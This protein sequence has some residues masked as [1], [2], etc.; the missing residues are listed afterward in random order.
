MFYNKYVYLSTKITVLILGSLT[1]I[2]KKIYEEYFK[3]DYL[4]S[5]CLKLN[6]FLIIF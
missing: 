1:K 2:Y 5:Y 6:K 3:V 4:S